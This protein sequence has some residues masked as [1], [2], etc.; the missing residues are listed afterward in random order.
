MGVIRKG[1]RRAV[2]VRVRRAKV[3]ANIR[4][5]VGEGGGGGGEGGDILGKRSS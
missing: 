5:G 4:G 1:E 3:P 2:A